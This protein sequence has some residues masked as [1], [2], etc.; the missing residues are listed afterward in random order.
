MFCPNYYDYNR[1]SYR[2]VELVHRQYF[3]CPLKILKEN[4][5]VD[6]GWKEPLKDPFLL[7]SRTMILNFFSSYSIELYFLT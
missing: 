5:L 4:S 3:T 2:M 7:F 1:L 6:V